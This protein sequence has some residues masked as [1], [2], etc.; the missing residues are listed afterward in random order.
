MRMLTAAV[1][2][3]LGSLIFAQAAAA[4]VSCSLVRAVPLGGWPDADAVYWREVIMKEV[5]ERVHVFIERGA[6][7]PKSWQ[8]HGNTASLT[9]GKIVHSVHIERERAS[10]K[11]QDGIVP[12]TVAIPSYRIE[13]SSESGIERETYTVTNLIFRLPVAPEYLQR[14]GAVSPVHI[15]AVC[16]R[17]RGP[18]VAG[19]VYRKR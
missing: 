14:I 15:D 10:A 6:F 19:V 2:P 11:V 17:P 1:L 7:I 16:E 12:G 9:S 4:A 13:T 3:L 8:M 18:A 5:A